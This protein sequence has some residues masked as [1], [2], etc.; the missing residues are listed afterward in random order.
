MGF[1]FVAARAAR[2]R[3]LIRSYHAHEGRH[4]DSMNDLAAAHQ[5]P[6]AG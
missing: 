2:C 5:R 4:Y 3:S 6:A 1:L